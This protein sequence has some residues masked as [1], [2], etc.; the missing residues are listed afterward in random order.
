[1][2]YIFEKTHAINE[3]EGQSEF[4]R[5]SLPT[6]ILDGADDTEQYATGDATPGA[7]LQPR[8][9]FATFFLCDLALTQR[10][11]GQ[12]IPPGA[13]PPAQPRQGKAP[14]NC[15]IFNWLQI[16]RIDLTS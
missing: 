9:P 14:H 11:G 2:G 6:P 15:F 16:F 4:L 10:A 3:L 5:C 1:M 8:V 7:V 12:A 13:A